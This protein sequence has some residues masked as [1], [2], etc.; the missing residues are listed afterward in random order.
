[1]GCISHH[2]WLDSFQQFN[3]GNCL[4]R[5]FSWFLARSSVQKEEVPFSWSEALMA[6][7]FRHSSDLILLLPFMKVLAFCSEFLLQHLPWLLFS[8]VKNATRMLLSPPSTCMTAYCR[9]KQRPLQV[10][11]LLWCLLKCSTFK[12]LLQSLNSSLFLDLHI[13][14][15]SFFL[16]FLCCMQVLRLLWVYVLHAVIESDLWVLE[17]LWSQVWLAMVGNLCFIC[18]ENVILYKKI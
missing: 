8:R 9:R 16:K 4:Q 1:M 6:S 15:L 3:T 17:I 5:Q 18:F 7:V 13:H 10:S 2:H 11:C 12:P 14:C